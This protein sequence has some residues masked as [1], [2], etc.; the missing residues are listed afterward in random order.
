M[1]RFTFFSRLAALVALS[2]V[3]V[4]LGGCKEPAGSNA[5]ALVVGSQDVTVKSVQQYA[6]P[7]DA[8]YVYYICQITWTNADA[9]M[10][11]RIERF[12]LIGRD[13]DRYPGIE[14]GAVALVG[15][16]NYR[17]TVK[18]AASQDYTI[19]YHVLANTVGSIY[20]DNT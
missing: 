4:V 11:P 5:Q 1:Q 7:N 19:G 14:S 18:H 3:V 12:V 10:V 6:D 17:G 8:K 2:S 15:I 20:Y 13:Q 9:D 16:T